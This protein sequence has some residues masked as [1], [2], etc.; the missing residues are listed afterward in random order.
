MI[1]II[2]A[3]FIFAQADKEVIDI[4][5]AIF[6]MEKKVIVADFLKLEQNDPFWEL[7][8]AYET[9]RKELGHE[10]IQLMREFMDKYS[11]LSE[12]KATSIVKKAIAKR[13]ELDMII[14]KYYWKIHNT[15]GAK[16]AAQFYQ[17]ENFFLSASRMKVF[18]TL[19][20]IVNVE[21]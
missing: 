2:L 17:I 13:K 11:A 5:Q 8:D 15:S 18:S 7:Y 20:F 6:G 4:Y 10:R 16:V 19:P 14:E 1:K 3:N 9:E 12:E 21:D